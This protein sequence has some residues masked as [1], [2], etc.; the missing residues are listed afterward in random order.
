MKKLF[1]LA[2]ALMGVLAANAQTDMERFARQAFTQGN[3]SDAVE[4]YNAA[5]SLTGDGKSKA[6][7]NVALQQAKKC[8][9]ILAEAQ[10]LYDSGK[11]DDALKQYRML[12]TINPSDS[13]A[14]ARAEKCNYKIRAEAVRNRDNLHWSKAKKENTA[15][16]FRDYIKHNPK[17]LHVKEAEIYIAED[18]L[19]IT[20]VSEGTQMAY[21][22]YLTTTTLGFH[23]EEAEQ[24]IRVFKDNAAWS[25]ALREDGR[26]GYDEY[27]QEFGTRAMH[28]GKAVSKVALFDA[29]SAYRNKDYSRARDKFE[30]AKK[31]YDLSAAESGMYIHCCEEDDYRSM[32]RFPELGKGYA[33]LDNYPSSV[34]RKEVRNMI[35]LQECEAGNFSEALLYAE[36]AETRNIVR[37]KEKERKKKERDDWRMRESALKA[38]RRASMDWSGVFQGG[39]GGEIAWGKNI[40]YPSIPV[41]FRIG[42]C[43]QLFNIFIGEHFTWGYG[44]NRNGTEYEPVLIS[45]QYSTSLQF[46]FNVWD[47]SMGNDAHMFIAAGGNFNVNTNPRTD[48]FAISANEKR[49]EKLEENVL[50]R[51]NWSGRFSI[52]VGGAI[53]DI[54]I[55]AMYD[56]TP[57]YNVENVNNGV[58]TYE[59]DRKIVEQRLSEYGNIQ[60]QI[61]NR[62]RVGVSL[63]FYIGHGFD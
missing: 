13:T 58:L 52:G 26:N 60:N 31:Y 14:S 56:I 24:K 41:E 59:M 35:A 51:T 36:D 42:R 28:Y 6:S 3:Y 33:F 25:N 54:S 4:L 37:Q 45:T 20:S 43:N 49:K 5:I 46:R 27:L 39:I 55:Y 48:E 15:D 29:R 38:T 9:L 23:K 1:L 47:I 53:A 44:S 61:H 18:E 11:Y 32:K 63:K 7:L 12:L 22:N 17:G 57:M 16:A 62:F 8:L 34:Y 10:K 30:I 50:H 19:W 40:C 2:I 21:E